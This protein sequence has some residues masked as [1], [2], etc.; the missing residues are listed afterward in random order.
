MDKQEFIQK[1]NAIEA[2]ILEKKGWSP[3]TM[4]IY[5]D[6]L[7]LIRLLIQDSASKNKVLIP[8]IHMAEFS[9]CCDNWIGYSAELD[10]LH[11]INPILDRSIC[12][13]DFLQ[14]NISKKFDKIVLFK[15]G[16]KREYEI[17][18]IEKSL[19]C[20]NND[21]SLILLV[22]QRFLSAP[23]Y[24]P[25]RQK[26]L[27]NFSLEAVFPIKNLSKA[28]T[29]NCAIVVIK[30][31]KQ[32][33][34]IYLP[35]QQFDFE[36]TYKNQNNAEFFLGRSE[37]TFEN[38]KGEKECS[39][40]DSAE[41]NNRIDPEYY[42]PEN[43]QY[44][45]DL[46]EKKTIALQEIADVFPTNRIDFN[47]ETGKHI[48]KR[49]HGDYVY[50]TPRHIRNGKISLGDEHNDFCLKEDLER[51]PSEVKYILKLIK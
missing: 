44:R 15:L 36:R 22:S 31:S 20:L 27:D 10:I 45:K 8:N 23:R 43:V 51:F 18:Y 9:L 1:Y 11:E 25:I 47:P 3:T 21:G 41:I 49:T 4:P 29:L 28:T 7:Y 2:R 14:A 6:I 12:Q 46:H 33:P 35:T 30:K 13:E 42:T 5:A 34:K 48:E 17:A 37:E 50:I 16:T 38:Y 19:D 39:W 24:T 26:I 32:S 40:V